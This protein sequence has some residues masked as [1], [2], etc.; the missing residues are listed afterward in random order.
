SC[1]DKETSSDT[2]NLDQDKI[3]KCP[4]CP[5]RFAQALELADHLSVHSHMCSVCK[6]TFPTKQKLE[7]HEQCHVAAATQYECTEC[8]NSFL[9]SDSFRQHNCA[10]KKQ[11]FYNCPVCNKRFSSSNNLQDH[12]RLHDNFRPFKCLP[13]GCPICGKIFPYKSV[14]KIHLRIHSGEKPYTCRVCGKAFTQACTVRVH[15]RVHWSIKPFLCSKCGKGFSQIGTLKAHTCAGK[16]QVHST[17]KEMELAGVV[18][19]RCHLCREC[20]STRDEYDPHLQTHTDNQRYSCE[21]CGQKYGLRSEL[22]THSK[23]CFSMWLAKTKPFNRLASAKLHTKQAPT[24]K[25]VQ[26][27]PYELSRYT[28]LGTWNSCSYKRCLKKMTCS[29]V[30]TSESVHHLFCLRSK[31][32]FIVNIKNHIKASLT[33]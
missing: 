3:Y 28:H 31:Q 4:I 33:S 20:F 1:L 29:A 32:P 15:E 6:K 8:G 9:G 30:Q 18:T 12:Q 11:D 10:R 7:E 5:E 26:S 22:D 16:P 21:R 19:F 14:L 2:N 25:T 13:V 17:L 24:D 27:S 23:Y